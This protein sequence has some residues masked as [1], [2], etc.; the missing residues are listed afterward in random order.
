MVQL[1]EVTLGRGVFDCRVEVD[2]TLEFALHFADET[3]C[4]EG[5]GAGELAEVQ[6][7]EQ[8]GGSVRGI[9]FADLPTDVDA[10]NGQGGAL[11]VGG[12]KLGAVETGFCELHPGVRVGRGL[13]VALAG[14]NE[15]ALGAF[16]ETR[17]VGGAVGTGCQRG[18]IDHHRAG[19]DDRH[20]SPECV[21]RRAHG[22]AAGKRLAGE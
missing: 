19:R 2:G 9:P 4:A 14:L 21:Q 3:Q 22:P 11:G 1:A 16:E 10:L 6:G 13:G 12:G 5:F 8:M 18:G 7:E 15:G 20:E 17:G